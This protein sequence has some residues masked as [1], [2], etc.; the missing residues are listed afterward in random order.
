MEGDTGLDPQRRVR[1]AATTGIA[2]AYALSVAVFAVRLLNS[3]MP[4]L[5]E[6]AG[7]VSL[8]V[9]MAVS[10]TLALLALRGRTALF[11]PAALI[12][13][14]QSPILYF[15]GV[16][17]IV[18]AFIWIWAFLRLGSELGFVRTLSAVL[19]VGVLWIAAAAA[20]FIHIDPVCVEWLADGTVRSVSASDQGFTSGWVWNQPNTITG[21]SFGAA[22]VVR[23]ACSSDILTPIEAVVAL[24]LSL[25]AVGAGAA[26]VIPP[27]DE[28]DGFLAG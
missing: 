11:L 23:S 3:D 10:P 4:I 28:A 25:S 18:A 20:L 6:I 17:L 5:Y 21:E 7:A 12:A 16:I 9:V 13:F 19:A 26:I 15:L 24:A 27:S 14:A 8:A 1:R 2:L 22:D